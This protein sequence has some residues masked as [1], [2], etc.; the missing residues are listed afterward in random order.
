[1]KDR[2]YQDGFYTLSEKVRDVELRRSKALKIFN[3]FKQ[4][5][6]YGLDSAVCLDIGCSSGDVTVELA[7]LFNRTLGLDYDEVALDRITREKKGPVTFFRGDAMHL[8]F[9]RASVD[10]IICAQV[11]EHVPD[12]A[13]MFREIYQVLKPGGVVFFSGPNWLF[14][15]EPHYFLPFLHWLPLPLADAYLRLMGKGKHYYER[16]YHGWKLRRLLNNFIIQDVTIDVL[17]EA[18]MHYVFGLR[19]IPTILWRILLPLFPNF[20]WILYKPL[21]DVGTSR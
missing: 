16:L 8:P 19:Y 14:P 4:K 17:R 11:Y 18:Y 2:G 13:R 5:V 10:V 20:N 12:A 3:I 15:I 6:H 7:P 1:M 9:R 21:P